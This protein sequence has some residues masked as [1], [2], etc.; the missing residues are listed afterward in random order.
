MRET[1]VRVGYTPLQLLPARVRVGSTPPRG[2]LRR[3]GLSASRNGCTTRNDGYRRRGAA[4]DGGVSALDREFK[5]A[6]AAL[7]DVGREQGLADGLD[8]VASKLR[9]GPVGRLMHWL[10]RQR[11]SNSSGIK[12]AT[13]W[14]RK[15]TSNNIPFAPRPLP[16][17]PSHLPRFHH[18]HVVAVVK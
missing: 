15:C 4:C 14:V 12:C 1:Q 17:L 2:E 16:L 18:L 6:M 8:A 9:G 7:A 10:R 13:T 11:A 5:W 3:S